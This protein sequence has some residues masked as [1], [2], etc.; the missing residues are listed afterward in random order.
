MKINNITLFNIHFNTKINELEH[1]ELNCYY[2]ISKQIA[3]K[4][5]I[6]TYIFAV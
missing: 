6:N 2:I 3:S 4:F 1:C 5:K